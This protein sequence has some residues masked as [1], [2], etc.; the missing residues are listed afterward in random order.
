MCRVVVW[1]SG[2][3]KCLSWGDKWGPARGSG[4]GEYYV[5]Y[6]L[7]SLLITPGQLGSIYHTIVFHTSVM[8]S[9]T[10]YTCITVFYQLV[11][12][13]H[14]NLQ[15]HFVVLEM[16]I[17]KNCSAVFSCPTEYINDWLFCP[18]EYLFLLSKWNVQIEVRLNPQ[19]KLQSS[20]GSVC[21]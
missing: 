2:S 20:P 7:L 1:R 4:K 14:Q 5:P 11:S 18:A 16:N 21:R 17:K 15:F 3:L 9:L 10:Q 19:V 8:F 6:I 13:S 12:K